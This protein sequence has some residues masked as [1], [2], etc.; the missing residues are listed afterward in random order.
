[1]VR[2]C[3]LENV[4]TSQFFFI[5]FCL[6][7]LWFYEHHDDCVKHKFYVLATSHSAY[8]KLILLD[9]CAHDDTIV[10]EHFEKR[11]SSKSKTTNCFRL[12]LGTIIYWHSFFSCFFFLSK[13]RPKR[14]I[15]MPG[16]SLSS[17]NSL[18]PSS[19]CVKRECE[20]LNLYLSRL[21]FTATIP[22]IVSY[23]TQF[24]ISSTTIVLLAEN[25]INN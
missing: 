18:V 24:E 8:Q 21:C 6:V 4:W 5:L 10:F 14:F 1:M 2:F 11:P 17:A 22:R 3:F 12:L 9:L 13:S 7:E 23:S 19:H 15:A 16:L 25:P 20:S